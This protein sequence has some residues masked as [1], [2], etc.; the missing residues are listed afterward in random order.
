[1]S[2]LSNKIYTSDYS[3]YLK[4]SKFIE[5][6]PLSVNVIIPIVGEF[7]YLGNQFEEYELE[8]YIKLGPLDPLVS[9]NLNPDFMFTYDSDSLVLVLSIPHEKFYKAHE[10]YKVGNIKVTDDTDRTL[11]HYY[12]GSLAFLD[13]EHEDL[14]RGYLLSELIEL[15]NDIIVKGDIPTFNESNASVTKEIY[16]LITDNN[17]KEKTLQEILDGF[18]YSRTYTSYKFKHVT[19]LN[20][21]DY[22]RLRRVCVAFNNIDQSINEVIYLSGFRNEKILK[23]A[24]RLITT[25]PYKDI[26]KKLKSSEVMEDIFDSETFKNFLSY[27][28]SLKLKTGDDGEVI[29]HTEDVEYV[30]DDYEPKYELSKIWKNVADFRLYKH[31][32]NIAFADKIKKY[33]RDLDFN[34]YRVQLLADLRG[35]YYADYG[36]GSIKRLTLPSIRNLFVH[37]AEESNI[38][39]GLDF[40]SL[41]Y[42]HFSD[43]REEDVDEIMPQLLEREELLTFINHFDKSYIKNMSFEVSLHD[44]LDAEDPDKAISI[45]TKVLRPFAEHMRKH[46]MGKRIRKGIHLRNVTTD[47]IKKVDKLYAKLLENDVAPHFLSFDIRAV[48]STTDVNNLDHLLF[49]YRETLNSLADTTMYLNRKWDISIYITHF[50][51]G[52]DFSNLNQE[53]LDLFFNTFVIEGVNKGSRAIDG[54]SAVSVLG[55]NK[56]Y[57]IELYNRYG[58]KTITYYTMLLLN[59]IKGSVIYNRSGCTILKDEDDFYIVLYSG[60]E[61]SFASLQNEAFLNYTWISTVRF[62]DLSGSFKVTRYTVDYSHGNYNYVMKDFDHG[63]YFNKEEWYYIETM[64]RPKMSTERIKSEDNLIIKTVMKPFDFNVIKVEQFR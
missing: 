51:V 27:V 58:F 12:V 38:I 49:S 13:I 30:I 57:D 16:D 63:D 20:L 32:Q 53:H 24:L 4:N 52:L 48:D 8:N 33:L 56:I 5:C 2:L 10:N 44:I 34:T 14:D 23:D 3:I 25:I 29:S 64:S 21:V 31:N 1:M 9:T 37:F 60:T 18:S 7:Y 17:T 45:A 62:R 11:L 59:K 15:L 46:V 36:N 19:N 47:N 35:N 55:K 6:D 26:R 41:T 61:R 54:I 22:L 42:E 40:F 39:L 50:L 43:V 28:K